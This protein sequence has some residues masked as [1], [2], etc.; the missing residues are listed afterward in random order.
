MHSCVRRYAVRGD[1]DNSHLRSG[2]VG[3]FGLVR[4]AAGGDMLQRTAEAGPLDFNTV[5]GPAAL[6]TG[7]SMILFAFASAAVEVAFRQGLVQRFGVPKQQA[8]AQ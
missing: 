4:A 2:A 5:I 6:Y 3:A 1:V 8:T 7:E